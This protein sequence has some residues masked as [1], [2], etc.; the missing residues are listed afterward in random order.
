M[1][2]EAT[3]NG[4]HPQEPWWQPDAGERRLTY[5]EPQAR[6]LA[7]RAEA[8]RQVLAGEATRKNAAALLGL[9]EGAL[10]VHVDRARAATAKRQQTDSSVPERD[11]GVSGG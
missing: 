7:R 1:T 4:R 3:T 9:S 10:K 6:W 5:R 11:T 8:V 2:V